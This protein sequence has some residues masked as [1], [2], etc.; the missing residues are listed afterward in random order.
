VSEAPA[1]HPSPFALPEGREPI[2]LHD[3]DLELRYPDRTVGGRGRIELVLLPTP[4]FAFS[5]ENVPVFLDAGSADELVV[6]GLAGSLGA[7][8]GNSRVGLSG[9]ITGSTEGSAGEGDTPSLVGVRFLVANVPSFIGDPLHGIS[10]H[11]AGRSGN[12]YWRGRLTL[13]TADWLIDLDLRIDHQAVYAR[14]KEQ[15]GYEIT[16]AGV[17]RR[18]NGTPFSGRDAEEILDALGEFLGLACGAWAPPI[19]AIGLDEDEQLVWLELKRRWTSPWR[20]HLRSFDLHKHELSD[21]FA[22]YF[23]RRSDPTWKESLRVATQIY[24]EANGPITVDT[25]LVLAQSALELISW[26][27][28]VDELGTHEA[29]DFDGLR[30]SERLREL[31]AWLDVE[32][33]IPPQ[34][35]ALAS[36][37]ANQNWADGPH[38]IGAMR[39][40]LIHPRQRERLLRTPSIARIELQELALW[41]VELAVLRLIDFN[42]SYFNRLGEKATGIVEPVPWK[43]PTCEH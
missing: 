5:I 27:R 42:G 15:G 35:T 7:V 8:A 38:A 22:C 28:F 29:T 41:Y 3:G 1:P 30:P 34:H 2:P 39:N 26:V 16:H 37:A 32:P 40:A 11:P 36:E 9:F 4:R 13:R 23:A 33:T 19:A 6:V 20:S 24:V 25:S 18:E 17:L 21:A 10:S 12:T 31:L 14:L 43:Q